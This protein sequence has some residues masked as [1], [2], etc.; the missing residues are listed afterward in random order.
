MWRR[1]LSSNKEAQ[2]L[3]VNYGF[4]NNPF[5]HLKNWRNL[6]RISM[7]V[8][9]GSTVNP[10]FDDHQVTA[11]AGGVV[12]RS[13]RSCPLRGSVARP[14]AAYVGLC[15][16]FKRDGAGGIRRVLS[17]APQSPS[18]IA[19]VWVNRFRCPRCGKPYYWRLHQTR[20]KNWRD[21]RHC[22]LA[23]GAIPI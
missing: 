2:D 7:S 5:G 3:I 13:V 6:N 15:S 8:S 12:A 11:I 1:R 4:V 17:H 23:Q 22:G 16:R 10:P 14:R 20:L 19:A 18:A 21:C 9:I